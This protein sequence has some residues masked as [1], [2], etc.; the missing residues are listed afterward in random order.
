MGNTKK[1]TYKKYVRNNDPH[2]LTFGG[3]SAER[4]PWEVPIER[5]I[6]GLNKSLGDA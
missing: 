1:L 3:R 2:L 4:D 6:E 5:P